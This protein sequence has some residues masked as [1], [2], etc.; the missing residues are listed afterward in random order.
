VAAQFHVPQADAFAADAEA[1]L[2]LRQGNVAAAERWAAAAGLSLTDSPTH[3]REPAYLTYARLLLA[4]NRPVEAQTLLANCERFA[5]EGGRHRSLIT[6]RILQALVQDKLGQRQ[7]AVLHLEDALRLAAPGEY[8]RAFLDVGAAV[9][10]LLPR[11][12]QAAPAFVD[13]LLAGS[14]PSPPSPSPHPQPLLEPLSERELEVL[15]LVVNGLSNREIAEALF[16]SVGTVKT[17]T[18]HIYGKLGVSSRPRAIAR[19]RELDL[20]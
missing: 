9:L 12:R 3:L 1:D 4:Q 14:E 16:I 20:V 7:Q 17:H 5:R 15:G 13:S 6:V 11:A 2:Q 19:A 18:H 8:R 10:D